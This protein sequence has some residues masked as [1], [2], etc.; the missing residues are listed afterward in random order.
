MEDKNE[1]DGVVAEVFSYHAPDPHQVAYMK[2]IRESARDL[3][4]TILD[5]APECPDRTVAIRKLREAVM[6]ANASIVL[7]GARI[8]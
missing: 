4:F 2:R 7:K 6:F 3:A 5:R 1:Q 8:T